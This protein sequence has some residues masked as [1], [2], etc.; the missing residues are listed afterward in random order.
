MCTAPNLGA[1]C[2]LQLQVFYLVESVESMASPLVISESASIA[3]NLSRSYPSPKK[4]RTDIEIIGTSKGQYVWFYSFGD[5][6]MFGVRRASLGA[7]VE[8]FRTLRGNSAGNLCFSLTC[9]D[10]QVTN[11]KI[12]EIRP[13]ADDSP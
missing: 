10:S 9:N 4:R 5:I 2:Y 7:T 12:V 13:F 1:S 8:S 6:P 3:S 11:L